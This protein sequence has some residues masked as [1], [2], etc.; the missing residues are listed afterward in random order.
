[1]FFSEISK[2]TN[3]VHG[4]RGHWTS[5]KFYINVFLMFD[6]TTLGTFIEFW[7]IGLFKGGG[8]NATIS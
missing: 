7:L 2:K 3:K 1:M 6:L 5:T 8:G 4:V